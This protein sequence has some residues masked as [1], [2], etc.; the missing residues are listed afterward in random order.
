M[1]VPVNMQHEFQH[2]LVL[3]S[4]HQQSGG[5]PS[6]M[7]ILVRTVHTVQTVDFHRY[8]FW[9]VVDAPVVVQWQVLW[10]VAQKTVESPQL[11]WFWASSSSWTWS[12]C[13]LVQRLG[14]RNAWFDCGYMFCFIQGGFWKNFYDFLHQGVDSAPELDARPGRRAVDNGSGMYHTGFA[15]STHLALCSHDC[16]QSV[17]CFSCSRVALGN[18]YI[19]ST[20]PLCFQHFPQSNFCAS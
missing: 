18:L 17:R 20:I 7:Q 3:L 13:P 11:Q 8:S 6:C 5:H 1:G 4:V 9:L 2:S 15:G 16:R 14:A 12:L 10:L 19:I